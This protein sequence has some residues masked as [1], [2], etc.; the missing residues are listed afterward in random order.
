MFGRWCSIIVFPL[1]LLWSFCGQAGS[2][3]SS[4]LDFSE[5]S[6]E[7]DTLYARKIGSTRFLDPV[8]GDQLVSENVTQS[9]SVWDGYYAE[10]PFVLNSVALH[11]HLDVHIVSATATS[12]IEIDITRNGN[13]IFTTSIYELPPGPTGDRQLDLFTSED[14]YPT[15]TFNQ[16][17]ELGFYFRRVDNLNPCN[18]RYNGAGGRDD[19]HLTIEF[20]KPNYALMELSPIEFDV[21]LE[22][23]DV[24]DTTL[25]IASVGRRTLRYNLYLPEGL[26]TLH[27]DDGIPQHWWPISD[28]YGRDFFNVRLT[29][30]QTCTLKTSRFLLAEDGSPG[31]SDLMVYVW[32]DSQGFPATKLDSALIVRD[33]LHFS[34]EWQVVDWSAKAS[35]LQGHN[36][37]HIGYTSISHSLGDSLALYSDNGLP[38]GNQRRSS[39]L[40]G[41]NWKTLYQ[42]YDIDANLMI[43]ARVDYGAKSGWINLDPLQG[44][45]QPGNV[46][47]VD[48]QLDASGLNAG[49]YK[50]SV[51]IKSDAPERLVTVPIT[52]RVGQTPVE[53]NVLDA[54]P[55]RSSLSANYPNPFNAGTRIVYQVGSSD[56]G[57]V[58][59]NVRLVV[60]N[61]L[62]QQVRKLVDRAQNPGWYSVWWDGRN[63]AGLEAAS[64]V[65]LYRFEV[66]DFRQVRKMLLIR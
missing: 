56:P 65:Y 7:S 17:D 13:I 40:L 21:I 28:Q 5:K 51:V 11:L 14:I 48:L 61:P 32:D 50:S 29:P 33:S 12:K 64:G 59:Q 60:Y 42:H 34:P 31:N 27:Y 25:E 26:D 62:G 3:N 46:Q 9:L 37:F 30:A 41:E 45:L 44:Q 47:Q 35:L 24:L 16:R 19:S 23:E 2:E 18:F 20:E 22:E 38:V 66:G 52:M 8:A 54:I 39:M 1:L 10:S 4:Y 53:E 57:N 49:I 55:L 43:R 63:E 36:D 58:L 15:V 6:P